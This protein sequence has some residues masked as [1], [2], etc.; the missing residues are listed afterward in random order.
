M[1]TKYSDKKTFSLRI[2]EIDVELFQKKYP[3]YLSI[4]LRECVRCAIVD[5]SFVKSLITYKEIFTSDS[6]V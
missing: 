3:N 2:S 1:K 4:F 6:T 5:D